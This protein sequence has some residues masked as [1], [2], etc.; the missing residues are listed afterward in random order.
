M[1]L[2]GSKIIRDETNTN[3]YHRP[4]QRTRRGY[5]HCHNSFVGGLFCTDLYL[6]DSEQTPEC[7]WNF[8]AV[9]FY[10]PI[11]LFVYPEKT[12]GDER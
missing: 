9:R 5:G 4:E 8:L 7:Q 2:C 6:P 1:C 3:L 10:M 12:S 11:G